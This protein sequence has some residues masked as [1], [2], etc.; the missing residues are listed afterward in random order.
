LLHAI[1]SAAKALLP[2]QGVP[3]PW[4]AKPFERQRLD[5]AATAIRKLREAGA[6]VLGKLAMVELA[7]GLGYTI[8]GA[9][10]TGAA[11]NPWDTGRWTCGS[12]SGSGAAVAAGLVGFALGSETWGSIVCP[13]SFCGVSG[14]RPTFGR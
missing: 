12:S 6:V 9:S 11:R 7:G 3:T 4:G 1:P 14:I 2:T 10:L 8:P 13:S 5:E